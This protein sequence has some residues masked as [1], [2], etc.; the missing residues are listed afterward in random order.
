MEDYSL[1]AGWPLPSNLGRSGE[2]K[3]CAPVNGIA[4]ANELIAEIKRKL[5]WFSIGFFVKKHQRETR[6]NSQIP[7]FGR[8]INNFL[9]T[10]VEG[11]SPSQMGAAGENFHVP[12][13][14]TSEIL[15]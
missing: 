12:C 2:R 5:D 14:R 7:K 13:T 11:W 3:G 6:S 4:N 8:K 15:P 9:E 10:G 1:L